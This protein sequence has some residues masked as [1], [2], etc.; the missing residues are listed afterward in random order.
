MSPDD[1]DDE[2]FLK[3]HS[4]PIT[5]TAPLRLEV[6]ARVAFPD[7][8]VKLASLRREISRGRLAYEV[9][10]GKHF[11]TL[12]DIAEMRKLARVQAKV[13]GRRILHRDIARPSDLTGPTPQER[14]QAILS[15]RLQKRLKK[16]SDTKSRSRPR[17]MREGVEVGDQRQK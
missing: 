13:G 5:E 14:L 10:A 2:K 1:R 11:T 8:S 6:A 15:Q 9:I 12:A 17:K 3:L 4:E 16:D 7:G